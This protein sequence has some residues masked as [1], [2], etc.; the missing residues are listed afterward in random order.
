M[1]K[2][3][4]TLSAIVAV[5]ALSSCEDKVLLACTDASIVEAD[6][7]SVEKMVPAF[8]PVAG[9][10]ETIEIKIDTR[11]ARQTFEGFG[12]AFSEMDWDAM[13]LLTPAEKEAIFKDLFAPGY[14][15]NFIKNRVPTA[16]SDYARGWYSYNEYEGDFGME[17]FSIENDYTSLIP[18]MK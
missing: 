3:F 9:D 11:N 1:E 17:H 5:S 14:G 13:G 6:L 2:L 4:Y 15:M 7:P 10:A 12:T 8:S 16:A 18:Y